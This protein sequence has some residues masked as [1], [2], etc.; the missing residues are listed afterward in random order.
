M[1]LGFLTL[2]HCS[3]CITDPILSVWF[4]KNV[5]LREAYL[6]SCLTYWMSLEKECQSTENV[7][8]GEVSL[9]RR[10]R[11]VEHYSM[12]LGHHPLRWRG[13]SYYDER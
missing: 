4:R 13:L 7:G 6:L 1:V 12:G 9:R 11:G 3:C 10:R 5:E 8:D 2:L